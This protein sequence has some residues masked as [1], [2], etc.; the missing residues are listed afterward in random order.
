MKKEGIT[1]ISL[2]SQGNLVVE[3]GNLKQTVADN[4]LTPEQAEIKE[5]FQQL[6]EQGGQTY[7]SQ[8]ELEETIAEENNLNK[9]DKNN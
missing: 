9:T 5:F 4:S 2:N 8:K 1:N 7:L 6:K 3:Y